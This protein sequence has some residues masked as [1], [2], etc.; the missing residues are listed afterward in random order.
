MQRKAVNL[1]KCLSC[2][3][4]VRDA[5]KLNENERQKQSSVSSEINKDAIRRVTKSLKHRKNK[6]KL[7]EY[8][9]IFTINTNDNKA[10]SKAET[11]LYSTGN[12]PE[13]VCSHY[14]FAT[15]LP[16]DLN[17]KFITEN[18]SEKRK[19][20]QKIENSFLDVTIKPLMRNIPQSYNS[21]AI[22]NTATS[23]IPKD[24]PS[25][26]PIKPRRG[27]FNVNFNS[28]FLDAVRNPSHPNRGSVIS[29]EVILRSPS[30]YK[31]RNALNL[32]IVNMRRSSVMEKSVKPIL[33]ENPLKKVKEEIPQIKRLKVIVE[34]SI[35][36]KLEI[37]KIPKVDVKNTNNVA[38]MLQLKQKQRNHPSKV[39]QK[40]KET[41][42]NAERK[43]VWTGE[44]G[45]FDSGRLKTW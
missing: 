15:N 11:T 17:H 7:F 9:S 6:K 37:H 4:T 41:V 16:S 44:N 3:V 24:S 5:R 40:S 22:L 36:R 27:S 8:K 34:T 20:I 31:K 19:E 14:T 21:Q 2:P 43:R 30:L 29:K 1:V 38:S 39:S 13:G 35:P 10:Y 23:R 45:K 12:T 33:E 42:S 18:E 26:S 32:D 25:S 28:P